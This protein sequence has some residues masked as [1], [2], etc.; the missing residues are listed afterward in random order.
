MPHQIIFPII[1]AVVIYFMVNLNLAYWYQIFVFAAALVLISN[2]GTSLGLFFASVFE[3]LQI[4]LAVTPMTIIP[5]MIFS[6]LFV[7][8]GALD[9][10]FVWIAWI[11]PIRYGYEV[12]IKNRECPSSLPFFILTID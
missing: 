4:A 10:W 2:C 3:N 11:S 9:P 8:I 12:L 5:L 7:N 1:Q 6:G